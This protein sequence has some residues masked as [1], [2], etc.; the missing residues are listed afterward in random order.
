[1]TN[2][3]D[4]V[5]SHP[6]QLRQFCC[7]EI[8]FLRLDC[9]PDFIKG[10]NWNEY[11][12]FMHVLTGGKRMSSREKSWILDEGSTVFVKKGGVTVERISPE[13]FCVLMFFVPDDYLRSFVSEQVSSNSFINPYEYPNDHLLPV[14]S[15]PVMSAFYDSILSYFSSNTRPAENL[16]ELKFKEL[17]LNIITNEKNRELTG[18]LYRLTQTTADDLQNIMESNCL[19]NMQLHEYARLCHRSL[20]SYKRD[21]YQTFGITPGRWLLEK[22]LTHA[23]HLLLHSDK[24]I[25]EV[26]CESGF[27]NITHFDKAFKKQYGSSPLHYRKQALAST[28]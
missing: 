18:Y 19:Y 14:C 7:K 13:P 20:S 27:K 6:E 2:F 26:M 25:T 22:R 11:N 17:L 28:T 1:M 16:L 21:F 23:S 15:S 4:Y 3:Y 12:I 5:R 24:S 8:L 10:E 9:P